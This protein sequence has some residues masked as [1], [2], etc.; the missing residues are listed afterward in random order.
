ML[1]R[2]RE[3]LDLHLE[4]FTSSWLL[5]PLVLISLVACG[6]A[7]T[8]EDAP[9]TEQ[10]AELVGTVWLWQEFQ[11]SAEGEEASN[12][13]VAD[14]AKYTLTLNAEGGVGIQADCNLVN[15]GYELEGS[16]LTFD[17]TGPSTLAYCGEESL[18]QRYLERL[19]HTATYVLSEGKL[20][21]N[22]MADAGNMVFVAAE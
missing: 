19:G 20:Y 18:D 11:D 14:P 22:L 9:R 15:W 4:Q 10:A 3:D 13:I 12:I 1:A 7:E 5:T 21:L 16:R 2:M 8:Q 17:A 6:C